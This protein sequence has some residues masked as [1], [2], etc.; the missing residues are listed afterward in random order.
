MKG[1]D[2]MGTL[3]SKIARLAS[4]FDVTGNQ[5]FFR[6]HGLLLGC[7]PVAKRKTAVAEV[8]SQFDGKRAE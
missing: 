7:C 6:S 4:D 3:E 8:G 5:M 1:I 2:S